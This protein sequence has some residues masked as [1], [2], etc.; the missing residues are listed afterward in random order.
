M[1]KLSKRELWLSWILLVLLSVIWGS[2]YILIKRGLVAYDPL[3]L[4]SVRLI[5]SALTFLPVFFFIYKSVDWSKWQ[6]LLIIGLTGNAI[7][8]WLFAKAQTKLSSSLAGVLNSLTPLFTL[9]LAIVIFNLPFKRNT[10]AGVFLGFIGAITLAWFGESSGA[11]SDSTYVLY[12]V[13]AAFCY[14]ISANTVASKLKGSS[15]M[16]L[17]AASFMFLLPIAVVLFFGSEAH[18]TTLQDPRGW[19]A[20]GYVALLAI[21]STVI[22]TVLYYRL[23]QMTGAVVSSFVSYLVPAVAAGW[24]LYDGEPITL[25][26]FVGMGLILLGVYIARKE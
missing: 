22:A 7:P 12:V 2:S 10:I 16:T 14:A 8:A 15:S 21:A 9:L 3:Q 24:G 1:E 23:V 25:F 26:T 20:F 11:T 13:G 18:T 4:A 17:S 5:V 6:Y 19:E